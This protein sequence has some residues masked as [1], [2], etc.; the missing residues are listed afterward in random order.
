MDSERSG[1]CHIWLG[2]C[3][4]TA[5]GWKSAFYP[6]GAASDSYLSFYSQAFPA[7][8]IDST[9]YAIPPVHSVESWAAHTPEGFCFTAKAPR[10]IT[11]D[12][13]M[14]GALP[15]VEAFCRA[16]E[17]LG[18]RLGP[19]LLQFPYFNRQTFPDDAL[20]LNRLRSFLPGLPRE[21][22]WA[23][24]IRNR[25]WIGP[26]LLDLLRASS[27]AFTFISHPWMPEPEEYERPADLITAPFSYIRWLGDRHRIEELTTSWDQTLVDRTDDLK[28]WVGVVRTLEPL[29]KDIF[30]FA[31]NHYSGHSPATLREF[32]AL[33]G[34]GLLPSPPDNGRP[35]PLTLF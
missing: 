17:P 18:P 20:F 31:N 10:S 6:R 16:L 25:S 28:K 33:W 12:R 22:R 27:V 7:V 30:A 4:C 13:V 15:E 1:G 32:D 19:V 23:L 26:E 11:H 24:E 5:K 3:S 35:A 8:E 9:F 2:S 14:E 21:F 34:G 29:V